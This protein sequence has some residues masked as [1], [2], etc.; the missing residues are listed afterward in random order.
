MRS[1]LAAAL[2]ALPILT[3]CGQGERSAGQ[4]TVAPATLY[5]SNWEG[6]IGHDTLAG[7]EHRTGIN[8]VM[9]DIPDNV[10]LQTKLLI[11]HSGSDVV[12]PSSNFL[13]PLIA[14]GAVLIVI[15]R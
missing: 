11:G 5:F 6:E 1:G 12:V 13:Q 2:I 10:S 8:V 14:A 9:D 3:S 4:K 7:F 15:K